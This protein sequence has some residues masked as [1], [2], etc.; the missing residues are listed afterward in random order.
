VSWLLCKF[1]KSSGF[2]AKNHQRG[3]GF[4]LLMAGLGLDSAQLYSFFSFFFLLSDLENYRKFEN[5]VK[6]SDLFY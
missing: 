1:F 3:R 6:I 4:P 2:S 5:M